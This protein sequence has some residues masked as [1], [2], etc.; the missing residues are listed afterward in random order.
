MRDINFWSPKG[1]QGTT[2]LVCGTANA[3]SR[4]GETVQIVAEGDRANDTLAVF[5]SA[6][7]KE[8]SDEG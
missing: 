4:T 8:K 2:T 1:G 6:S 5:R 7:N 3:L